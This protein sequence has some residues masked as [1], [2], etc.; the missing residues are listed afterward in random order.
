MGGG[1]DLHVPKG[2]LG[3]PEAREASQNGAAAPTPCGGAL[4][5]FAWALAACLH[6]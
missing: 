6:A 3:G 5:T 4:L 1:G 2:A